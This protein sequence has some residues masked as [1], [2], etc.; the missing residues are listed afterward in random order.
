MPLIGEVKT[1]VFADGVT[2][3]APT[4]VQSQA[5]FTDTTGWTGSVTSITY[6]L[7]AANQSRVPDARLATWVVKKDNAGQ[8]GEQ[9]LAQISC[10]SATQVTV[11]V[12]EPL[13]FGTY[14]FFGSY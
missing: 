12:D 4:Q 13:P 10:P 2:V 8:P 1:L 5:Y 11:T 7:S 3:T 9:I 14:Y 6:T